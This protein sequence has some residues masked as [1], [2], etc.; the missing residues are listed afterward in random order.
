M[1]CD[2]GTA[3]MLYSVFAWMQNILCLVRIIPKIRKSEICFHTTHGCNNIA[4]STVLYDDCIPIA[5]LI[6]E[7][8]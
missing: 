3:V 2:L 5:N 1:C 7:S 6:D 4:I 8:L